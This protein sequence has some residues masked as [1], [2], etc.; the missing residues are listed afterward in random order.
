ME[1]KSLLKK[2]KHN[3]NGWSQYVS[4]MFILPLLLAVIVFGGYV[5]QSIRVMGTLDHALKIISD[6]MTQNGALT[7]EGQEQLRAYIDKS[8]L[9]V[10]KIYL[11]ATTAPQ[12]Y[13]SRGLQATIGYDWDIRAPG[14]ANV[15]WH[16]Y[17]E[18]SLPIAQSQ[19]IPGSGAD[20]SG[21]VPIS[22]VFT[23]VQ[24]GTGSGGAT[25]G[26]SS[27][28]LATSMTMTSNT[29]SPVANASVII[30]GKVYVGSNTA[31]AGTQVTLN[32]GGVRQT[33]S[34]DSSGNYTANVAFSSQGTVVLQG[35]SGTAT[36]NIT[37][38]VQPS[39]PAT[40][41]LQVPTT[42]QIG[43]SF[44][45]VGKV[46]DSS[47]N[48]VADNTVVTISSSN[49][50]IPPTNVF[51]R[52][53]SFT[54]T[55]DAIKTLNSFTITAS[56]GSATVT[57]SVNVIPG[58]PESITLHVSPSTV[59]A[60][61]TVTFSG[62]VL[63]PYGTS[64]AVNT[65]INII[66]ATNVVD[67]MPSAVTD[68]QG[69]FS[70]TATL[71]KAG[72]HVFY[73]QTTG[74]INSPTVTASVTSSV[75]Y[76]VNNLSQTPNPLNAG[77]NL[78]ISGY[79]S[80]QYDNPISSG[81]TLLIKS[82]SGD[83][84]SA[85]VQNGT[86]N[87]HV[88]IKESGIQTLT[89][90][91]SSGNPLVGG[92]FTVTVLATSAFTITPEQGLYT[93]KAGQSIG[94]I[95][96]ILKDSNGQP[97]A[98]K[99]VK[100]TEMPQGDS[101]LSPL[102]AITD[103]NGRVQT[104]VGVLTKVGTHTLMTTLEDDPNIIGTVGITVNPGAPAT[105]LVNVSPSSTQVYTDSKPV[106]LPIV[107]GTVTDS[108][109]NPIKGATVK[110]SGGFGAT[111]SGSTD[112][113][114]Y[115]SIPIKPTVVGGPYTLS[116]NITSIYG[117]YTTSRGTITVTAAPVVP[118]EKVLEGVTI[119]GYTGNMPNMATR[120][121]NGVG[122]GRSQAITYW[123]GGGST[124]FLKPQKGY[125]D[126]TDTW[127]YVNEPNLKPENIRKG[128]SILGVTGNMSAG[129]EVGDRIMFS[130]IGLE[131]E[132]KTLNE[133]SY[134]QF[135]NTSEAFW[136]NFIGNVGIASFNHGNGRTSLFTSNN[137][138]GSLD[139]KSDPRI[140]F[141]IT[142]GNNYYAILTAQD[143]QYWPTQWF[144]Q[145]YKLDK[146]LNKTSLN[147][148]LPENKSYGPS[149]LTAGEDRILYAGFYDYS[150]SRII[151]YKVDPN[152]FTLIGTVSLSM[153]HIS[154]NSINESE[155]LN[156][157]VDASG[158]IYIADITTDSYEGIRTNVYKYSRTGSL[159]SSYVGSKIAR[160]GYSSWA[161]RNK[162]SIAGKG[163][164][165]YIV[166]TQFNLLKI[167]TNTMKSVWSYTLNP[168]PLGQNQYGQ[169]Q[170]DRPNVQVASDGYITVDYIGSNGWSS[171]RRVVILT[172]E[173]EEFFATNITAN[174]PNVF[175]DGVNALWWVENADGGFGYYNKYF[176]KLQFCTTITE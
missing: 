2:L 5:G 119:L 142:Y 26:S 17:Y 143:S 28:I 95:K 161:F 100:F 116:F 79:V 137:N 29:T 151:V 105:V 128:L 155:R 120:N 49:A 139:Y 78:S 21:S 35:S 83:N 24:G 175:Y 114:G 98:G 7:A 115:Y 117:N 3:D 87:T 124:I 99:K 106:P 92:N 59:T 136:A 73:A 85:T 11:N 48:I 50:D 159:V 104:T 71:T 51:T 37:F 126:G 66:S 69:N 89:V 74:S 19:L 1:L 54:Y 145:L 47:G 84:Y 150:N 129:Y 31:P 146:Y 138:T 171:V 14:S 131:L 76:K 149:F 88:T 77:A 168:Y 81:I 121:P 144:Y 103:T 53:G 80:D 25:S 27:G 154:P 20:T 43:N 63:G 140:C 13:G 34:T 134:Q 58:R 56:A 39:V 8:G 141:P 165:L 172:P 68:E 96:F 60:G 41:T 70:M 170:P 176:R 166:D 162:I 110:I 94:S 30:S 40:I 135:S 160:F 16:K 32:G 113:N 61:S 6:N 72:S 55:V 46:V 82:S 65:P 107:S 173:K 18:K 132:T 45:V 108:F 42:V 93:V 23:G 97:V 127:T 174:S 52:Y 101:L 4:F 156:A 152:S 86:F 111:V 148:S 90:A 64:P 147:L 122:V 67:T 167:D 118:V 38:N 12:S 15:I 33:V 125:Y 57:K 130:K 22:S 10:S 109:G 157:Y 91:D 133:G 112:D 75:P 163:G 169:G 158:Y 44:G 36:A 123:T 153:T 164:F 62:K 102:S 9:D